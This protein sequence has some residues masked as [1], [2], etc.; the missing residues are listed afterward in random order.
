MNSVQSFH[1]RSASAYIGF[2]ICATALQGTLLAN[3]KPSDVIGSRII[4]TITNRS[5]VARPQDL[6]ATTIAALAPDGMGGFGFIPGAGQSNGTFTIAKVPSGPFWFRF[7]SSYVWTNKHTLDLDIYSYGRPEAAT[8]T[9]NTPLTFNVTGL[10][11]FA[12][13]DVLQWYSTNVNNVYGY[14]GDFSPTNVPLP[15]DT[16][17]AG[18]T[19]DW[20]D[21]GLLMVDTSKGDSPSLTQLSSVTSGTE[22][23]TALSRIFKPDGLVQVDGFTSTL[24]GFMRPVSQSEKV[25]IA[26]DRTPYADYISLVNPNAISLSQRFIVHTPPWGTE[27]GFIAATVDLLNYYP[28]S[29]DMTPLD[30]GEAHYGNPFPCEWGR[31][32]SIE[33]VYAVRYTAPGTIRP[34]ALWAGMATYSLEAPERSKPMVQ[35]VAPITDL[36][37]EGVDGLQAQDLS[38]ATPTLT[39]KAPNKGVPNAYRVTVYRVYAQG[40]ATRANFE[41][42]LITTDTSLTVPPG[43]LEP[44]ENYAFLV[45]AIQAKGANPS[46]APYRLSTFPFAVAQVLTGMVHVIP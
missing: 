2:F 17:L 24:N 20:L 11:P 21:T 41:A 46:R 39:W 31:I 38:V 37:I 22:T 4:R 44:G 6:S 42:E 30:L 19:Q 9:Q 27:R 28:S 32:Y 25:R 5:E 36:M 26:W 45:S 14:L 16:A 3:E 1:N 7:G 43:I 10:K 29:P 40:I 23:Y 18:M 34:W 15:G 12:S 8:A 33:Q 35:A 13:S